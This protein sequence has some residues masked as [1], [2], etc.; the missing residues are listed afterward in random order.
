MTP[1]SGAG[2]VPE[3]PFIL[4]P[5]ESTALSAANGQ[6]VQPD[7]HPPLRLSSS[8]RTFVEALLRTDDVTKAQIEARVRKEDLT[9]WFG[10]HEFAVYVSERLREVAVARGITRSSLFAFGRDVMTER[11]KPSKLALRAWEKLLDVVIAIEAIE[12]AAER[13]ESDGAAGRPRKASVFGAWNVTPREH[14]AVLTHT[15]PPAVVPEPESR[16]TTD[17]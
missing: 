10:V 4:P 5:P 3:E 14:D 12:S 11:V 7:N 15:P 13:A 17:A 8:Q 16:P 9:R 2:A 1:E 6:V